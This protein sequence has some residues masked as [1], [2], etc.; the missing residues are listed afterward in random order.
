MRF[1][2]IYIY[3]YTLVQHSTIY[4]Q[5]N[6]IV[7][8]LKIIIFLLLISNVVDIYDTLKRC[9]NISKYAGGIG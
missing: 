7:L 4:T 3:I 9:I 8:F 2:Y 5:N 6:T 1:I